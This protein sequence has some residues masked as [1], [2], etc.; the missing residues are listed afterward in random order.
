MPLPKLEDIKKRRNALN[1]KQ[2]KLAEKAD[3]TRAMISKIENGHHSLS[4]NT[5]A[6]IFDYLETRESDDMKEGKTAGKIC[7]P[8]LVTI[9]SYNTI[10]TAKK[11]MKP[12]GLS[13]LPVIDNGVCVGL[14]TIDSI[15]NNMDAKKVE[16]AMTEI[17]PTIISEDIVITRQIRALIH[18]SSCVLVSERNSTSIKGIIT[19]WDLLDKLYG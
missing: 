10:K 19:D 18:D 5:A 7:M 8:N 1:I 12:K 3:V 15:L 13:Q 9:N 17:I 4:Y 14:I 16:N 2:D 11:K 6:R